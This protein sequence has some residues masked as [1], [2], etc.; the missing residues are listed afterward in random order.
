MTNREKFAK[1]ILDIACSGEKLAMR[2]ADKCLTECVNLNCDD[3]F[4]SGTWDCCEAIRK[5]A[6]SEYIEQPKISKKDR[7]FLDYLKYY[8]YMARD[9]CGELYVYITK[10]KK[11]LRNWA[12]ARFKSL[13]RLDIDFPM[14]KWSD[15]EPWKIDDLKKLE[16][17]NEY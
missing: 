9:S 2:K 14:V 16:V 11:G 12:D 13:A 4:F 6:E 15:D 1:E 10:P 8:K 3:C 17:V 5:W 7:A